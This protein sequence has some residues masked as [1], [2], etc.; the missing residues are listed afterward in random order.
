MRNTNAKKRAG[1][2]DVDSD[3]LFGKCKRESNPKKT[4]RGPHT[5]RKFKYGKELSPRGLERESTQ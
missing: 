5:K 3:Y 2:E 4:T 1:Q